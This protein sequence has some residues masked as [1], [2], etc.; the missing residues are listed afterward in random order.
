LCGDATLETAAGSCVKISVE[1]TG[2]GIREE[3]AAKLFEPFVRLESPLRSR[4][5]GTGLGLYLTRKLAREVLGGDISF[6]SEYG[7]GSRFVLTI[8]V[9]VPAAPRKAGNEDADC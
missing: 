9:N 6:T 1:D 2:I 7:R 3:D 8:P 5:A 4:V